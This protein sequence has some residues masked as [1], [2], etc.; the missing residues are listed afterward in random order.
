MKIGNLYEYGVN[1]E[2][3]TFSSCMSRFNWVKGAE[4]R[5]CFSYKVN[6]KV[7]YFLQSISQSETLDQEKLS[8]QITGQ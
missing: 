4:L 6:I 1:V 8:I 7:I 2:Q 3:F 5:V